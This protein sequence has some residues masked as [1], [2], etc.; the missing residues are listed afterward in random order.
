MGWPGDARDRALR[1]LGALIRAV[2]AA[3]FTCVE[4]RD[5]VPRVVLRTSTGIVVQVR[6]DAPAGVFVWGADGLGADERRLGQRHPVTDVS[7]A[8]RA[9]VDFVGAL[10]VG[11]GDQRE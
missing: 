9:L 1:L 5:A 3:G 11:S 6:V 4:L 2:V 8:A 7:G 10:G